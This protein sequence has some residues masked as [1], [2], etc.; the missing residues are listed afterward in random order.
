MDNPRFVDDENIQLLY[1]EDRD[2]D[3]DDYNT[4]NTSIIQETMSTDPY[5]TETTLNL[6]LRQK[7]KRDKLAALHRHLNVTVDP[8]LADKDRFV[9]K[10]SSNTVNT[11]LFF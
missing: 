1:D 5:T 10:K 9:L 11:N 3:Y 7:V 2:N 8:G 6:R 4:P